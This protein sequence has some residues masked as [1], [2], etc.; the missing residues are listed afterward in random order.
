MSVS[1][2]E[3]LLIEI[4][5]DVGSAD[6]I[7]TLPPS[8]YRDALRRHHGL[9]VNFETKKEA[10]VSRRVREIVQWLENASSEVME[11]TTGFFE[12]D[13]GVGEHT[14]GASQKVSEPL[15]FIK[16]NVLGVRVCQS[17]KRGIWHAYC[18]R[19]EYY[20]LL[21]VVFAGYVVSETFLGALNVQ[22]RKRGMPLAVKHE[23]TIDWFAGFWDAE[24]SVPEHGFNLNIGQ[25][26]RYVLEAI[27]SVFGGRVFVQKERGYS[28]IHGWSVC[29]KTGSVELANQ[30]WR[31]THH[32]KRREQLESLLTRVYIADHNL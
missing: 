4:F 20:Q 26:E 10:K 30:L 23:P 12:G 25:K 17:K 22:L 24:G 11:Y 19:R 29:R 16:A 14:T 3:R 1:G 13:G 27:Q 21:L 8:V 31:R 7:K 28:D 9:D 2:S 15:D 18:A 6:V 32:P 5:G